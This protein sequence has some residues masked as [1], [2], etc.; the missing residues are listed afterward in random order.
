LPEHGFKT[1]VSCEPVLDTNCIELAEAVLPFVT[2]AVWIGKANQLMER[3]ALNCGN[4]PQ[5]H[6]A[7]YQLLKS[8][9]VAWANQLYAHFKDNPKVKWKHN[10]KIILGLDIPSAE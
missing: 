1:S 9:S 3:I 5:V 8:Q 7:A 10:M 6:D 4:N 2:D